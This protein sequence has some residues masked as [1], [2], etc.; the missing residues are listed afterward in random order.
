MRRA[1]RHLLGI[2]LLALLG[3]TVAES[4]LAR[5]GGL[6]NIDGTSPITGKPVKLATYAGKPLVL[7][8]WA[9]WCPECNAEAPTIAAAAAHARGIAFIGID[10]ADHA[11]DAR[12][13][14]RRHG[15]HF[16]SIDDPAR[17]R[18]ASLGV[19]GQPSTVFVNARG[20]I[21]ARIIGPASASQLAAGIKLATKR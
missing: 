17:T 11:H 21:I 5:Q 1:R 4:A 10:I 13:F 14:Y 15:W 16:V 12:G 9:S 19:P 6:P 18:M 20:T 7:H 3:L 2:C 8:V